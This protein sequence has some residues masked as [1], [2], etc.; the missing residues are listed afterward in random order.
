M[1]DWVHTGKSFIVNNVINVSVMCVEC[2]QMCRT[3]VFTKWLRNK[4]I[5]LP[6]SSEF[7]WNL[8]AR[9]FLKIEMKKFREFFVVFS[10]NWARICVDYAYFLHRLISIFS[11]SLCFSSFKCKMCIWFLICPFKAHKLLP[12]LHLISYSTRWLSRKN[13]HRFTHHHA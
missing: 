10:S 13:K 1:C 5:C 3:I 8:P 2:M 4:R 9:K 6:M 11:H 7:C 12:L